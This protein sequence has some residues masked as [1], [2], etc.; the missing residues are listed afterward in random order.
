MLW[1]HNFLALH[2]RTI[3]HLIQPNFRTYFGLSRFDGFSA[4]DGGSGGKLK[5]FRTG[6]VTHGSELTFNEFLDLFKSFRSVLTSDLGHPTR[7]TKLLCL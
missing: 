3:V 7:S 6:S 4:D 1:L 5:T 2:F